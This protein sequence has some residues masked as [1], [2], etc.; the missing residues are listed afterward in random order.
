M[1]PD[2][3][4]PISEYTRLRRSVGMDP[5]S[6]DNCAEAVAFAVVFDLLA[7]PWVAAEAD[8]HGFEERQVFMTAYACF[9]RWVAMQGV[10]SSFPPGSW[11][12]ISPLIDREFEKQP[13]FD[14]RMMA[15]MWEATLKAP[16]IGS[17]EGRY[18]RAS[19]GPW[20]D[21]AA[22]VTAAAGHPLKRLPD[23]R[24]S[25]EAMV[26]ATNLLKSIRRMAP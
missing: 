6:D 25:L 14:L 16:P 1:D 21:M 19:P 24:F 3:A 10:R 7:R 23:L 15:D 9:L 8:R 11:P 20:V 13:W 4:S 26:G 12:L 22:L 18:F 17:D 2:P 5:A